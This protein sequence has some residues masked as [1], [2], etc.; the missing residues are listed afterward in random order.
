VVAPIAIGFRNHG[1]PKGPPYEEA[2][3]DDHAR[4]TPSLIAARNRGE[5]PASLLQVLFIV[6]AR[7]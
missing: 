2:E 3:T 1:D 6:Q 7:Q 5:R 4:R